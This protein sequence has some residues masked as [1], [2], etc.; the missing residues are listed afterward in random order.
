[1]SVSHL[2]DDVQEYLQLFHIRQ[3]LS[4]EKRTLDA[5]IR[6]LSK[7][8]SVRMDRQDVDIYPVESKGEETEVFGKP[9]LVQLKTRREYE[10]PTLDNLRKWLVEFCDFIFEEESAETKTKMGWG[11][12]N[13]LWNN[14]GETVRSMLVRS[15]FDENKKKKAKAKAKAKGRDR[16]AEAERRKMEIAET[17]TSKE[18]F[19]ALPAIGMFREFMRAAA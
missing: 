2:P 18:E 7:K 12:A 6:E 15:Y 17:P 8:I 14:R 9:G 19:M 3:E 13:W 10:R 16:K 4:A 5:R 1:M 11:I